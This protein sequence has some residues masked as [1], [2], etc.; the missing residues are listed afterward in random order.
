MKGPV[1]VYWME[2]DRGTGV[3]PGACLEAGT[4]K[5]R[6]PGQEEAEARGG[7]FQVIVR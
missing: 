2:G 5:F 1:D 6:R 7:N 3:W 4:D